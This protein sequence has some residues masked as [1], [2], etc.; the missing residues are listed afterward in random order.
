MT[1]LQATKNADEGP[2]IATAPLG[3][4]FTAE[5]LKNQCRTT[6]GAVAWPGKRP[7][8]ALVLAVTGG[9]KYVPYEIHVLAEA[10]SGDL[11]ELIRKCDVLDAQYAPERWIG[12]D[13]KQAAEKLIEELVASRRPKN[14]DE[15][16][17]RVFSGVSRNSLV[18]MGNGLYEYAMPMLKSML[19]EGNR[20]LFLKTSKAR[21]HMGEIKEEE[22]PFMERGDCPAVEALAFA[23]KE[24]LAWIERDKQPPHREK[25]SLRPLDPMAF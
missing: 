23:A 7:G 18:D 12:D 8:F 3:H 10:E 2:T 19:R 17:P 22:L 1:T 13:R 15:E 16:P 5:E 14:D 6:I 4:P 25:Y 21:D 20:K 11:A 9:K 24:A